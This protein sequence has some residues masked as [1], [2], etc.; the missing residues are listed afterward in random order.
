[1]DYDIE[2]LVGEMDFTSNQIQSVGKNLLLTN[3]EIEVLNRYKINYLKCTSLKEVLFEIEELLGEEEI[4]DEDLELISESISERD[5]YQN[6]N[7]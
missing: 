6:T 2:E 3:H 4:V 7:Q 5:Y 1:M